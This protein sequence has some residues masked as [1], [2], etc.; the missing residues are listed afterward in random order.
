MKVGLNSNFYNYT[1]NFKFEK[2]LRIIVV[3]K[4]NGNSSHWHIIAK[5]R[6]LDNWKIFM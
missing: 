6:R 5:P 4:K 3:E 2:Y 1:Y